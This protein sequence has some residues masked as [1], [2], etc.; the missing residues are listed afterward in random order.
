MDR[1]RGQIGAVRSQCGRDRRACDRIAS[2][3]PARP[4]ADQRIGCEPQQTG[5]D[6]LGVVIGRQP[7]SDRNV[8]DRECEAGQREPIGAGRDEATDDTLASGRQLRTRAELVER[9]ANVMGLAGGERGVDKCEIVDCFG[10]LIG[11]RHAPDRDLIDDRGQRGQTLCDRRVWIGSDRGELVHRGS[12]YTRRGMA[13]PYR[14]ARELLDDAVNLAFDLAQRQ[15]AVYTEVGFLPRATDEFS[16]AFVAFSD[17]RAL[18]DGGR[19]PRPEAL[20]KVAE[21]D[22][23]IVAAGEHLDARLDASRAAGAPLPLDDLRVQLGLSA[24]EFRVLVVVLA[25]ETNQRMRQLMRYL[26]NDAARLH[27]DVGLLELLVYH[28]PALREQWVRELASDAPLFRYRLL[29]PIGRGDEPF[30]ARAFRL[31]PR[32][33]EAAVGLTRLDPTLAGCAELVEAP[34]AFDLLELPR[35]TKDQVVALIDDALAAGRTGARRPVVLVQGPEGSGRRS[36]V[37]GAAAALNLRVVRVRCADL[38]TDPGALARIAQAIGREALL[39]QAL[40]VLEDVDSLAP[41]L[42]T[43]RPDRAAVLD[44]ALLDEF[45]G[46]VAAIGGR[47]DAKPLRL[48][49]GV[50]AIELGVPTEAI[51]GKLWRRALG[52]GPG[53]GELADRAAARYPITGGVIVRAADSAKAATGA[54]GDRMT[55]DDVHAGVRSALDSKLS[56][57]G[58]RL[59]WK[60]TWAELVL[61]DDALDEVREF[62]GRVRH[63]KRV[64]DDWGFARKIAKGIGL[65][66]LFSGPPGTGKTMVAGLIADELALD[67]Y[68]IDLSRIVSKYVGE[69]EKNLASLFDAAEA[70]HAVLL[71]DEADSLFAKR[72]EVKSSVD[73]YANLEVNYLLQRMEA[74]S[75]I[76]I[77]T[78][79]LDASIDEAFRRRLSFRVTFPMPEVAEREKLWR[80]LLPTEAKV[81][82][83]VDFHA[84]ASRFEMSGGYIKNAVVRAAFLAAGEDRSIAMRHLERAGNLEYAAMGKV[85]HGAR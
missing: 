69:T 75:G 70:G 29:E 34:L 64:Y 46:A 51:R 61:P 58:V 41:E 67:L 52:D 82:A 84:L 12:L 27:P 39:A 54:R 65:S 76:T 72:T 42:E 31:S 22:A 21:L 77:L 18:L 78:T 83:G 32:V 48:A 56:T 38:P 62:V 14:N 73:R 1:E 16:G 59:T 24:T 15:I 2:D 50:V 25:I 11:R 85:M 63:R 57:L 19:P 68:Q 10:Q 37:A 80:A 4:R 33:I 60:Q 26:V 36:L 28:A 44:R 49:R 45:P 7:R 55:A 30:V 9:S 8:A 17:V 13:R 79:N 71:F 53:I 66:A 23:A 35:A 3:E 5:N 43:G 20:A 6:V 74:F 47:G 81:E 40:L